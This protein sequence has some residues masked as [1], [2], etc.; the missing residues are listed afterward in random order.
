MFLNRL[1]AV[2]FLFIWG[3]CMMI[4]AAYAVPHPP[5]I[6]PPI[7][8][9]AESKV[10]ET[11]CAYRE[12]MHAAAVLRPDTVVVISPHATCYGDYFHISPGVWA[13]GNFGTTRTLY[14]RCPRVRQRRMFRRG[15]SGK[16]RRRSIT[17]R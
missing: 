3:V 7:G 13:E 8:A 6:L 15:R 4:L 10:A 17:G 1:Q 12:V 16:R 5:L 2:G 11:T 14:A 9:G